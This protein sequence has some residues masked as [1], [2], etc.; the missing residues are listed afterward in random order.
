MYCFLPDQKTAS[1]IAM[2]MPG[3]L[4]AALGPRYFRIRGVQDM[5]AKEPRFML[6]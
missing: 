1:A 5:D 3:T 4:K 6:Q 2:K